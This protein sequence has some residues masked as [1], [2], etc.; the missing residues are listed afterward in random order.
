MQKKRYIKIDWRFDDHDVPRILP[1]DQNIDV[2][3]DLKMIL[4]GKSGNIVLRIEEF[5]PKPMRLALY[6]TKIADNEEHRP[7]LILILS[8]SATGRETDN[9]I[10]I[11]DFGRFSQNQEIFDICRVSGSNSL[12][13]EEPNKL[14]FNEFIKDCRGQLN[15]VIEL[16]AGIVTCVD[17][18]ISEAER[19]DAAIQTL[20]ETSK[21]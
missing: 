21:N 10:L 5:D 9:L 20:S 17:F 13:Q 14:I 2:D 15:S 7:A 16:I 3:E 19:K 1:L 8:D 11:H 12:V 18:N 4:Q 6:V